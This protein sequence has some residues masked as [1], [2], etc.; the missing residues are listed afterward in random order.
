MSDIATASVEQSNGIEQVNKALSQM[1]EV[2]QQ[3]SALVE[4]NAATAKALEDQSRA[5]TQTGRSLRR[6]RA[7][8]RRAAGATQR[9]AEASRRAAP[10]RRP[11]RRQARA[12]AAQDRRRSRAQDADGA[13]R[14][15]QGR[16]RLEGILG[17][18]PRSTRSSAE[19]HSASSTLRDARSR[20]C[21]NAK[22]VAENPVTKA[23]P[24]DDDTPTPTEQMSLEGDDA[25][26][27]YV[28]IARNLNAI[29]GQFADLEAALAEWAKISGATDDAEEAS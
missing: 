8:R 5:M 6:R 19:E 29:D 25:L 16:R 28:A 21:V 20:A 10:R 18:R 26:R 4:E 27:L 12:A 14:R 11:P 22:Y 23:A 13:C 7:R 9:A 1:D 3:N 2:T 17:Q 15:R 24:S